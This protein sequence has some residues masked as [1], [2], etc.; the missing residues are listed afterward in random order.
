MSR[1]PGRYDE[2]A[3]HEGGDAA[4]TDGRTPPRHARA[5]R[6]RVV[7]LPAVAGVMAALLLLTGGYAAYSYNRFV[8]GVTTV[9]AIPSPGGGGSDD[10]DDVD[11]VAQN[12]LLVGDDHRP[13]NATPEEL[14]L[15]STD[16]DGGATNT[17]TMIVLHIPADGASA[18]MISMPRDSY[19]D[20]PGYGKNKLNAAFSLGKQSGGSDAA[21]AQLL[22]QTVQNL[23]GLTMDHYVRVSL[24]G[25]YRVVDALGPVDVCLNQAAVD[26]FSGVNLPAGVSTLDAKQALSFVRQRHGLPGGDLDRQVRQQYFLSVEAR[27]IL[28]AGTLLNPA[29][30]GSVLDAVSSSMET[31]AGL[32]FLQLANQVRDLRPENVRSATIPILGTPTVYVGGSALSVVEVDEGAMPAFIQGLVGPPQAYTDA[33]AAAPADVSV[34]VANASGVT[35]AATVATD[36]LAAAGFVTAAPASAESTAATVVNYPAGQ[37]AQAKAVAAYLPGAVAVASSQVTSVTVVLGADGVTVQAPAV[38]PAPET[39]AE[40]AAP[41]APET[42]ETTAPEPAPSPSP[43]GTSYAAGACIN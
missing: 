36:A 24:I 7:V 40:T 1:R 19:V 25:F 30:L 15:L 13:D 5:R 18:T 34:S 43:V 9:D 39:P 20:I 26:S 37:E 35:G 38:A 22:I 2:T 21:G 6:R 23:T 27:K 3:P 10:S 41:D 17:D 14:A 16:S 28:S 4:A 11:G 8:G 32:N 12:I 33:T 29:K 42:P 31:D